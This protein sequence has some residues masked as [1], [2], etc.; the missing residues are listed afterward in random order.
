[1]YALFLPSD[2]APRPIVDVRLQ[3]PRFDAF[4]YPV[5]VQ[6]YLALL[7]GILPIEILSGLLVRIDCR[8]KEGQLG[9]VAETEA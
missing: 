3:R 2:L 5:R 4:V 1:M 6:D 9:R 8:S 7:A